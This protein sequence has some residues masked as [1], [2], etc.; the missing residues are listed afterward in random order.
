MLINAMRQNGIIGVQNI[1][2][3]VIQ[4]IAEHG[5]G[6]RSMNLDPLTKALHVAD[7]T[8]GANYDQAAIHAGYLFNYPREY[9]KWNF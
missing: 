8:R 5:L 1:K 6:D 4:A 7:V 3:D 9:P 2:P